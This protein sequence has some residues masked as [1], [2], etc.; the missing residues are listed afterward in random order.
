MPAHLSSSQ[1]ASK[2][3]AASLMVDDNGT[4]Y[5]DCR[6]IARLPI[7]DDKKVFATVQ[8]SKDAD[9]T[10]PRAVVPQLSPSAAESSHGIEK[11][12]ARMEIPPSILSPLS[13]HN[14]GTCTSY[15]GSHYST[16]RS[17]LSGTDGASSEHPRKPHGVR[18]LT[19]DQQQIER[20]A[21]PRRDQRSVVGPGEPNYGR[22]LNFTEEEERDRRRQEQHCH[23][24][25]R[26]PP[27]STAPSV[28]RAQPARVQLQPSRSETKEYSAPATVAISA[29]KMAYYEKLS[30][31]KKPTPVLEVVGSGGPPPPRSSSATFDRLAAPKKPVAPRSE[32]SSTQRERRPSSH[33][34][35][36]SALTQEQHNL[37]LQRLSQPKQRAVSN[38]HD[39]HAPLEHTQH[40]RYYG[41]TTPIL[42]PPGITSSLRPPRPHA[43]GRH[44]SRVPHVS[45]EALATLPGRHTSSTTASSSVLTGQ[46]TGGETELPQQA[47]N[48]SSQLP[49]SSK[50]ASSGVT[51]QQPALL[52]FQSSS[53]A[54]D[55]KGV[56][57][58]QVQSAPAKHTGSKPPIVVR[59]RRFVPLSDEQGVEA[60]AP[61][62]SGAAKKAIPAVALPKPVD[63]VQPRPANPIVLAGEK[64]TFLSIKGQQERP[65]TISAKLLATATPAPVAVQAIKRAAPPPS[66]ASVEATVL[67][68]M[69]Q[70]TEHLSSAPAAVAASPAPQVSIPLEA[71]KGPT[72]TPCCTETVAVVSHTEVPSHSAQPILPPHSSATSRCVSPP[73]PVKVISA[74]DNDN[75]LAA[76]NY[77]I[78]EKDAI[79]PSASGGTRAPHKLKQ[80]K[81]RRVKPEV[82]RDADFACQLMETSLDLR[83]SVAL[84]EK[85][86]TS[87]KRIVCKAPP[88]NAR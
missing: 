33:T 54:P 8:P 41:G 6:P 10:K 27:A 22:L 20:L 52:L 14:V 30:A 11:D 5:H 37:R 67:R 1:L 2:Q 32:E 49:L 79:P 42:A 88:L 47:Y 39:P 75:V 28:E 31:P 12:V 87:G 36:P 74:E 71:S 21:L 35:N 58:T 81:P 46:C 7:E 64:T 61:S 44:N 72:S 13:S 43:D 25:Q 50:S 78:N 23:A 80:K 3:A 73:T 4:A 53:S 16:H 69:M 84:E 19:A 57:T 29:A 63:V 9:A 85:T 18:T 40:K 51:V 70:A 83:R 34:S 45:W 60:A 24:L 59:T 26:T 76:S 17:I 38:H 82:L 65:D 77:A 62:A 48:V 56:R 68:S 86:N 66:L 55:A 15:H